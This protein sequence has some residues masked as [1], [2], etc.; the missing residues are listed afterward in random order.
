MSKVFNTKLGHI[1]PCELCCV[2]KVFKTEADTFYH[3]S[4]AMK[5]VFNA[6]KGHLL[7]CELCRKQNAQHRNRHFCHL[8][9]A[10]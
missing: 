5:N 1:L 7:P 8:S 4:W 6:E 9:C 3:R 2:D 10:V